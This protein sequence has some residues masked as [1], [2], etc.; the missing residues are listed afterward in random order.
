MFFIQANGPFFNLG[1]NLRTAQ[2]GIFPLAHVCEIDLVGEISIG[3][4]PSNA[5]RKFFCL[6]AFWI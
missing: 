6:I 5:N 4:L 3:V 1:T 2:H